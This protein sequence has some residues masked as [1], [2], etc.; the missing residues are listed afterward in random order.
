MPLR[1]GDRGRLERGGSVGSS[2]FED[3]RRSC[4]ERKEQHAEERAGWH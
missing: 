1:T 2:G 3:N 4:D